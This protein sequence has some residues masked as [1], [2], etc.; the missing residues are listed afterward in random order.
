MKYVLAVSGGIDSV[1]LLDMFVK[2]YG[3]HNLLVAHFDHG[4]RASSR[5]DALFVEQLA[6]KYAC[7][8]IGCREELGADVGE[9]HA[10]SRRYRFLHAVAGKEGARL[11]VAHHLDDLVET[12]V[13]QF[14]R[15]TG[16]RG[17]TPFGQDVERPLLSMTK[18][19]ILEYAAKNSLKWC[20]DETNQSGVYAR[21]RIRPAVAELQLD[22]KMQVVALYARQW[23][24]RRELE[25]GVADLLNSLGLD[26]VYDRKI[27]ESL[28]VAVQLEVFRLLVKQKLTRP[29]RMR[30]IAANQSMRSGAI[31]QAGAGVEIHFTSRTFTVKLLK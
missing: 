8:Y 14:Q 15:G 16:W 13:L 27:V 10:R 9:A 26:G 18:Q 28:S 3:A 1:V 21:N 7:A 22:T 19:D 11:V 30:C 23:E 24:L 17:L 2:K 4:I 6:E 12:V 31:F 29:Q 25:G 20:E 5:G